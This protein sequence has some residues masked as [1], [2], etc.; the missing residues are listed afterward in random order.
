MLGLVVAKE[1]PDLEE[2]KNA[3]IVSNA[4]MKADLKEI[5]DKILKLLNECKGSP[6]DDEELIATL[7]ASKVKSQEI[8]AKVKVA[9]ETE[10]DIDETRSK[11]VPVAIRTQILFFCTTDLTHVD[12]MYQYS[13]EWFREIFLK[14]IEKAEQSDDV[15]TRIRNINDH[16]TFSLYSNVCRSLFERHKLLF[17]FLVCSRILMNENKIDLNEWRFFQ[18][19]GSSTAEA[20]PNVASS[21]LSDRAWLEIQTLPTL[22]KF[23]EFAKTFG[24]HMDAWKRIFD[25]SDPHREPFPEPWASDLDD[26][27]RMLV[28]RCLRFDKVCYSVRFKSRY[29]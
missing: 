28:L 1:R 22:P 4:K 7:D 23:S 14:T 27:Q 9:E 19:G 15:Q 26:F 16:F 25:S 18:A 24:D 10:R 17:A 5:E 12:P 3:L 6:V 8:Q 11:Y 20:L 13:L 29:V 21:W 2:A